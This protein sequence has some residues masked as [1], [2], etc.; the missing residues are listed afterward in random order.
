MNELNMDTNSIN[1]DKTVNRE[2]IE[3]FVD[4]KKK[5]L[6]QLINVITSTTMSTSSSENSASVTLLACNFVLQYSTFLDE[7]TSGLRYL[8]TVTWF[9]HC[10][11]SSIQ[12][13]KLVLGETEQQCINRLL[14]LYNSMDFALIQQLNLIL[15]TLASH[16]K[17]VSN[18]V[19]G[20][21]ANKAAGLLSEGVYQ[22]VMTSG[23]DDVLLPLYLST[24]AHE[25]EQV[26]GEGN[27]VYC[28]V[29]P[30]AD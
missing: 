1:I 11:D 19:L 2:S 9:R 26:E 14:C 8:S 3:Q 21:L 30:T 25:N 20:P 17:H 5:A 10:L 23:A 29:Q 6:E 22:E 15:F 13:Q 12:L 27:N 4:R 28:F 18:D 16:V 7:G 24:S